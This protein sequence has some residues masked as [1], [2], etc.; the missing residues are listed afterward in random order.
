MPRAEEGRNW[1]V[2]AAGLG[3]SSE[4][5]EACCDQRVGSGAESRGYSKTTELY[6]LK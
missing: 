6:S 5:E 3:V 1:A 4:P 2:A